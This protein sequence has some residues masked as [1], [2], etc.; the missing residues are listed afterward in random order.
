[1]LQ[2]GWILGYGWAS[3]LGKHWDVQEICRV[4]AVVVVWG[5]R[6]VRLWRLGVRL[7]KYCASER[8]EI[9]M[10]CSVALGGWEAW[11]TGTGHWLFGGEIRKLGAG[12]RSATTYDG[13]K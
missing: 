10:W 7:W 2:G 11:G 8:W 12:L 1:M 5:R 13:S 4:E 6:A 3:G 9:V